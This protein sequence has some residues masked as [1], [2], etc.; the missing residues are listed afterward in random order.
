MGM[1]FFGKFLKRILMTTIRWLLMGMFF[2]G[3]I[4]KRILMT[5]IRWLLMGISFS[6]NLLERLLIRTTRWFM[7][8]IFVVDFK[9]KKSNERINITSLIEKPLIFMVQCITWILMRISLIDLKFQEL[10]DRRYEDNETSNGEALSNLIFSSS[11]DNKKEIIDRIFKVNENNERRRSRL[12]AKC[13]V[14]ISLNSLMLG[15]VVVSNNLVVLSS[16]V[17]VPF[18]FLAITVFMMVIYFGIENSHEI[19]IEFIKSKDDYIRNLFLVQ[20]NNEMRFMF[21]VD[22]YR[23]SMRFFLLGVIGISILGGYHILSF[24]KP[25]GIEDIF[26]DEKLREA[27]RCPLRCPQCSPGP[28]GLQENQGEVGKGAFQKRGSSDGTCPR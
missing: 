9:N 19:N 24:K 4:L 1:S 14:L 2:L 16:W 13:Q 10:C 22:V 6:G 28:M 26:K 21:R 27:L 12:D 11:E 8:I 7:I 25:V 5:T 3:K 23:S 15:F 18:I 17:L 20:K